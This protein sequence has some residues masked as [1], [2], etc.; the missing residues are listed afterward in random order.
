MH[1]FIKTDTGEKMKEKM[2]RFTYI[3]EDKKAK[4]HAERDIQTNYKHS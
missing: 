1:A 2:T 3:Q 4:N